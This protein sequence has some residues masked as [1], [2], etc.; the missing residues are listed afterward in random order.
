MTEWFAYLEISGESPWFNN[1]AYANTLD[2]ETVEAFL[3]STHEKYAEVLGE[4]FGKTV[5]AHFY[6]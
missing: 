2:K 6:R 3:A 5:P 1:Q 4:S